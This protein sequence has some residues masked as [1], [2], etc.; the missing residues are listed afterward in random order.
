MSEGKQVCPTCQGAGEVSTQEQSVHYEYADGKP[1]PNPRIVTIIV[2]KV[3]GTCRGN[4]W[5]D[6]HS[7]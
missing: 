3:C 7:R 6:G 2:L 4:R 5:L 1:L